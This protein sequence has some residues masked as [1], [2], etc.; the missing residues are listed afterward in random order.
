MANGL[1][2]TF[3]KEGIQMANKDMKKCLTSLTIR[4]IQI[5]STRRY[6]LYPLRW[7]LSKKEKIRAGEDVEKLETLCTVGRNVKWCSCHERQYGESSNN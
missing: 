7:L 1:E 4:K 2:W 3:S 5:N 6:Q